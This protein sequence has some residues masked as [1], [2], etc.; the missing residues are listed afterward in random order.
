M[1]QKSIVNT[2]ALLHKGTFIA[3]CTEKLA[4]AVKA[5][6]DT[7]KAGKLT[8]TIDL[9]KHAGALLVT[10]KVTNKVP[11]EK[12]DADLLWATV[13]GNLVQQNPAQQNLELHDTKAPTRKVAD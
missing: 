10:A 6:E 1:A 12:V 2:M 3:L 11:E 7:D 4:E 9:K 8:I 13:E 5:V